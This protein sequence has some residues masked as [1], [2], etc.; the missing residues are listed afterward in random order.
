MTDDELI[1]QYIEYDPHRHG[2]SN[3]YLR[4]YGTPVWAIIG[5]WKA[6]GGHHLE[7]A[8]A[9]GVPGEAVV[10]ALAYYRHYAKFIDERLDDSDD[11][12]IA[13][14]LTG[15]DAEFVVKHIASHP[16]R[17]GRGNAI[18]SDSGI[19]VWAVIGNLQK[20]SGDV[21]ATAAHYRVAQEAVEAAQLY[22]QQHRPYIDAHLED[23]QE[24]G[25]DKSCSPT[26]N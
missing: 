8:A 13:E 19:S 18:L 6:N 17:E 25:K 15:A 2:K 22:Y 10:A 4:D 12:D 20:N 11:Y 26:T 5:A 21:A 7:T 1:Q 16:Y 3:A 24:D 9:Y 14:G 23:F